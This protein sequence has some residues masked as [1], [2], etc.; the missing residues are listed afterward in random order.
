M[1][2]TGTWPCAPT[3]LTAKDQKIHVKVSNG[4]IPQWGEVFGE[5]IVI[6][7]QRQRTE[8][9][10]PWLLPI[11]LHLPCVSDS[12]LLKP[13]V[14]CA[15]C[16]GEEEESRVLLMEEGTLTEAKQVAGLCVNAEEC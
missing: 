1:A 3:S 9:G 4:N 6:T 16:V 15:S 8:V 13:L 5:D 11:A 2:G 7:L 10:R 14:H 12:G